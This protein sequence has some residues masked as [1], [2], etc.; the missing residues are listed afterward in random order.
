MKYC[1][2]CEQNTIKEEL[3]KQ[4][5]IIENH[6]FSMMLPAQICK[7]PDCKEG[8]I[9]GVTT[10]YWEISIAYSLIAMGIRT[11][12]AKNFIKSV[13]GL[14]ENELDKLLEEVDS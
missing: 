1:T 2:H 10:Y 3:F 8:H 13:M 12:T 4:T 5:R 6:T 14:S 11:S 9:K 7:N